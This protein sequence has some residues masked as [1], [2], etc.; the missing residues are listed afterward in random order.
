MSTCV[1]IQHT[2]PFKSA[3]EIEEEARLLIE[4]WGTKKG[5]L[6]LSDYGDAQAIGVSDDVKKIMFDAFIKYAP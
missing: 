2:L 5:G 1:D 4:C 6:I 3:F